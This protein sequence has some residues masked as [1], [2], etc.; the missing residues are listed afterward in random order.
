MNGCEYLFHGE[1]TNAGTFPANVDVKCPTVGGV[2]STIEVH[3]Y[4]DA[5][6]PNSSAH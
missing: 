5:G 6:T 2:E 3:I 1:L 4:N